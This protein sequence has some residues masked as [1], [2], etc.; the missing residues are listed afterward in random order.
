MSSISMERIGLPLDAL[1][2]ISLE[3]QRDCLITLPPKS[4][5]SLRLGRNR[6]QLRRFTTLSSWID[7]LMA[8]STK[9][10]V[11]AIRAWLDCKG[12]RRSC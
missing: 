11:E 6:G 7:T 5:T 12:A 10:A 1:S 3:A 9:Q 8:N 4:P 2:R